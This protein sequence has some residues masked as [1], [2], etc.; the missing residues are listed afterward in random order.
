MHYRLFVAA[1]AIL[2]AAMAFSP[3][4]AHAQESKGRCKIYRTTGQPLIGE[5]IEYPDKYQVKIEGS[6]GKGSYTL[7][8]QKTEVRKI[9]VL[10]AA[11]P[12]ADG[13][14]PTAPRAA[15]GIVTDAMIEEILGSD[16]IEIGAVDVFDAVSVDVLGEL[17][18]N[19][20][21]VKDMERIAG[22][23][24][25][26]LTTP[27]FVFVYTSELELAKAMAANLERVYRW[28]AKF[29]DLMGVRST[30]PDHKLE[31]FFFGT[32]DEYQAYQSTNGFIQMGA[33]GFYMRT[34]N[35]SAFFNMHTWPPVAD[36][37]EQLKNA[38]PDARRRIENRI[39]RQME[40]LNAEVVQHEAAHHIHFNLG[41]FP[42]RGDMPRWMTEGLAQMFE[43]VAGE[44]GASWG[45]INHYRLF[46]FRQ[47]YGPNGER[48]GDIRT[49]ILNDGWWF[50][51][52]ASAY[53]M[54][55]ALNHYLSKSPE[56]KENYRKWMQL[57]ATREDDEEVSVTDKQSQFEKLFGELNDE[58]TKKFVAYMNTIQLK[59]SEVPDGP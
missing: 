58:W 14:S 29:N 44:A 26:R 56:H 41:T 16:N 27:H 55:W 4:S 21:S 57:M 9:E 11:E 10:D 50:S 43:V 37:H 18:I 13:S 23:K 3:I 6:G 32:Y 46:Q 47:I 17:P 19:E 35:R 45:A 20:S 48:I 8:L 28:V 7:T 36:L 5:L 49:I 24:A 1:A 25:K 15:R 30:R 2:A 52:G 59:M 12:S 33:I 51:L 54:G 40:H 38:P 31:I 34:N 53:P 39:R 42:K 22:P